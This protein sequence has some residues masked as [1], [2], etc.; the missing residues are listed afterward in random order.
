MLK[1]FIRNAGRA[2]P[3]TGYLT[4][5][6]IEYSE[7][8]RPCEFGMHAATEKKLNCVALARERTMPTE[9][10]PLLGDVVPTFADRGRCVV[11]EMDS[12]GR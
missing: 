9:R 8:V 12:N 4:L 2:A 1:Y 3:Y 5:F 7:C 10:P 6:I 11:S